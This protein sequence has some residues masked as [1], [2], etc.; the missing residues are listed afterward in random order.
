LKQSEVLYTDVFEKNLEAYESGLYRVISNQGST[1]SSKT[2]SLA[3]LLA[4][5]IPT[6]Y[7][8]SISIVSPSLPHLKRG[9]RRDFLEV[10][11]SSLAYNDDDFNKTDNI[12]RYDNG[13]YVE[14]FG[15]DE[16]GKVRGPGR[17][18]L[19]INEANLLPYSVYTQLAIRT[20]DIIFLDF[21]PADETSWVY[22][23]SDYLG[24]EAEGK[25]PSLLIHSTYKDNPFL[26]KDQVDEIEKLKDADQNL[27]KVYGLGLR[28]SS[29]HTIYT[30]WKMCSELPGKGEVFYGL[31]FG[32]Q[33]PSALIK[34]E[35]HEG[36]CYV[37]ESLYQRKLTT[38]DL[39]DE[40]RILGIGRSAEIFADCAEPK[41]IEEIRR[42]GYNVKESDKDVLAG[43]R[44]VRSMPL[45]VTERS[46]NIIKE[47]KNYKWK[48]DRNDKIVTPEQPV[49]FNDHAMDAIRYA[50]FTKLTGNHATWVAF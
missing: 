3:Q 50:V 26:S 9:A 38:S 40:L 46:A 47:I 19:Y 27:W 5:Y 35:I 10:M 45:R 29:E 24:N 16:P 30:H 2:F 41:T 48:L 4:L 6:R 33:N 42:E 28:G 11:E 8:K 37:D 20:R 31:D 22:D 32:Y 34:I 43:I 44:H 36:I 25:K 14:F 18:I 12:Y 21:N 49:K 13:S 1:R 15:A 39:I 7:K 23:V 17:D